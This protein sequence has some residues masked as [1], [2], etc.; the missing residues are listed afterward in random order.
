MHI[1]ILNLLQQTKVSFNIIRHADFQVPIAT[2]SDFAKVL[3]YVTDRI[4]KTL[5]MRD[6]EEPKYG[7]LVLPSPKRIDM[8]LATKL[9]GF[10]RLTMASRQELDTI[11]QYPPNG[12]SPIGGGALP[13]LLDQTLLQFP[14]VLIGAG[15][16]AVEIEINP[17]DLVRICAANVAA[18]SV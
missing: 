1:R 4:T 16:P 6:I 15:V 2:A 11:L 3:G 13:V 5:L 14:T 9:M 18:I 10:R 12:V 8:Q 17:L 7:L